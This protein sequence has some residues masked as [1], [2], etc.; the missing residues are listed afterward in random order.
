[1]IKIT[2]DNEEW[3]MC[4]IAGICNPYRNGKENMQRMLDR[5]QKRGPN[6]EGMWCSEDNCVVLGHR[7]LSIVDLS[8]NGAQPMVSRSGRYVISYNGE[9]YNCREI[10]EK[11]VKE[12]LV[13]SFRGTSDTEILLE[14]AE[15]Y[16]LDETLKLC[17]GMFAL[18]LYDRKEK[19]LSLARDRVGEKPL[20]Y[21]YVGD[22]FVFAS[23]LAAIAQLEWFDNEIDRD[24]LG[25]YFTHGY[26]PA[27]YSIYKGI[28]KLRPGTVLTVRYPYRKN[29][30][31]GHY[32]VRP[33]W[34]MIEAAR[35]G[36]QEKFTGNREEAADELERLLKEAIKYQMVADVPVGAFLSAGI[37]SSTVV[38]LMQAQA[39]GRVKTFTIGMKEN[40]FDEAGAAADI[41]AHLGTEHTELYISEADARAVI[42][43]ISGMFGEPF[44]DSSQIP[45]YLVSR[46]TREHVTVSL[47][48]DAG[49]ELFG[50]YTS[51]QSVSRVWNRIRHIP[52]PLRHG[53]SRLVLG[54]PAA[55]DERTRIHM[56]LLD[57]RDTADI[58][59]NSYE[60]YED[61]HDIA[62]AA[63]SCPYAYTEFDPHTLKSPVRN[64][65]L[66]DMLMYHP[67]DILAKVDR[68][69]MAV[70]L[71]TRVPL[72]DRHVVEFAWSLSMEYLINNGTGK[73]VLRD[74]LY[75]YV[76]KEMMDRPKKGFSIPLEKW[77]REPELRKWAESLIDRDMIIRQGVLNAD[78]VWNIWDDY[79]NN[80]VW[81]SQI[82]YILMFQE[83][84]MS[85]GR[86]K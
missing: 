36:E 66:M 78:T 60:V 38:S 37:D 18:A 35:R 39:P 40:G 64:V 56:T 19:T 58:Y 70:S 5:M 31:E 84:L 77:L 44:A 82:W 32:D 65:M 54:T 53:I 20:Y 9:I 7:R 26:I 33:Y 50:G 86:E 12:G 85:Q 15:S 10:A 83:W 16:G 34:S 69:A 47:S 67:D 45:T 27:P 14:A 46:M 63:G 42:P 75:R 43:E 68:T 29:E 74:V 71:E 1:M 23:D 4:G 41:A 59:R 80:G 6:A 24:V 21:G 2:H 11:L 28:G 8:A 30:N 13:Q 57:S 79:I 48:G 52:Y 55:S 17:T 25:I 3:Q 76:P 72:L 61:T 73:Q 22:S 49:D 51:Y 81:R 62:A